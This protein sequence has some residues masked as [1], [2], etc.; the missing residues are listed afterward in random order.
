MDDFHWNGQRMSLA[1]DA[2]AAVLRLFNPPLGYMD[3]LMESEL[4]QVLDRLEHWPDGRVV[5]L[6]GR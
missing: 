6:T 4:L 1:L 3:E 2:G 5:V